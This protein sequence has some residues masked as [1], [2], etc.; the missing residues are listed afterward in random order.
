MI[1]AET[2]SSAR[3]NLPYLQAGQMQK[4]VTLNEA[5]TRLDALVQAAVASRTTAEQPG[6]A[7]DGTLHI[8]PEDAVG[9]QWAGFAAGDLVRCEA[10]GWTLV[11]TAPGTRAYVLDEGRLVVRGE[12]GWSDVGGADRLDDL[13]G[14][15]VGTASDEVNP[16]AA[17]LNNALWTARSEG[18]GGTGDLR[19]VLNK[20]SGAHV[21]SLL[22]Q[23]GWS[24]RAEIGLVGTEDLVLKV[25]P[26]G[27][28]WREALGVDRHTGGV[29]LHGAGALL[30]DA[31]LRVLEAM[32]APPGRRRAFLIDD[33]VAAL[34]DTG[35]WERLDLFYVLAAGDEAGARI[36]WRDPGTHDLTAVGGPVFHRDQGFQGDGSGAFL[37]AGVGLGALS[38][39]AQTDATL[40]S[41]SLTH[42]FENG[43]PDLGAAGGTT[44]SIYGGSAA[45]NLGTAVNGSNINTSVATSRGLSAASRS[46][47]AVT[48]FKDGEPAGSTTQTPGS[49]AG[50]DVTVL[51]AGSSYSTRRIAAAGFGRSLDEA[52][53]RALHRALHAYLTAVGA[54]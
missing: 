33:L 19:Y 35:V 3:L 40:F 28:V 26:D 6:A 7:D 47:S 15:G 24:G 16:F 8:L 53:H 9:A 52:Q 1:P 49:V 41:W 43:R 48:I 38:Q 46:G 5:L 32:P 13:A 17:K 45:N 21:L 31:A 18:E 14:L 22:F 54:L 36:N 11:E 2:Q 50:G 25:S 34:E 30:G 20:E 27:D 29:R 42:L 4:H 44:S 51:R 23:S 12:S 39:Y 37:S 10:G